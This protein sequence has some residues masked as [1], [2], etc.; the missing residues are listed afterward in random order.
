MLYWAVQCLTGLSA[1]GS[2]VTPSS[3]PRPTL[4]WMRPTTW[5]PL[6][7]RCRLIV[8]GEENPKIEP[9]LLSLQPKH[10]LQTSLTNNNLIPKVLDSMRKQS[11]K[12]MPCIWN[13]RG[14]EMLCVLGFLKGCAVLPSRKSDQEISKTDFYQTIFLPKIR[15]KADPNSLYSRSKSDLF[16][17]LNSDNRQINF[18][19]IKINIYRNY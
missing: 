14:K 12:L 18:Y 11:Q 16:Q 2:A 5:T 8:A 7:R 13:K 10:S 15:P 4:G 1:S 17:K 3:P 19:L 9:T 6:T